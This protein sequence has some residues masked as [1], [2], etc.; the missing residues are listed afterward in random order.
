VR[1]ITSTGNNKAEKN[2]IRHEDTKAQSLMKAKCKVQNVKVKVKEY[3]I[4]A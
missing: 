3:K 4:M 2:A 1:R